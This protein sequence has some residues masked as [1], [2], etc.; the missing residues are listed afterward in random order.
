MSNPFAHATSVNGTRK[1]ADT[2]QVVDMPSLSDVGSVSLYI[3]ALRLV[4]KVLDYY[5][6]REC[7]QLLDTFVIISLSMNLQ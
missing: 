6:R 5:I 7:N 2:L 1:C 4:V 3:D